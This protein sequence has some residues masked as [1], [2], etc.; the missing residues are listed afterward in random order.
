[1]MGN[2]TAFLS[3]FYTLETAC[4]W[5]LV[6]LSPAVLAEA[7]HCTL[8]L[9]DRYDYTLDYKLDQVCGNGLICC[10]GWWVKVVNSAA[11]LAEAV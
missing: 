10:F 9:Y 11:V 4:L 5:W 7:V 1:M 6:W 8:R 3:N 2:V